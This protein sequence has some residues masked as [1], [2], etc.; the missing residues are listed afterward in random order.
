[1][2]PRPQAALALFLAR[3]GIAGAGVI[4]IP[5]P[6]YTL[7]ETV[8]S[9]TLLGHAHFCPRFGVETV[10]RILAQDRSVVDCR[11]SPSVTGMAR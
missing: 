5:M 11:W 7:V 4:F 3:V 2:S 6:W 9:C 8:A 1:M 10:C